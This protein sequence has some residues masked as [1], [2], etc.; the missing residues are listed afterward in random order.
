MYSLTINELTKEQFLQ[1]YWQKKPLL[2][3]AGFTD[4]NDPLSPEELAG[5]AMEEGIE[6][7]IVT[8]D[9]SW[10][11]LNGP[12]EDFSAL[13]ESDSTLL[14]QAVDHWHPEASQLLEPF[15]FIP[16][17]R[18]DDLMVSY[19]T[20]GG[21]VGPHLDQ[22][23]VFIIQGQGQRHW[24]VGEVNKNLRQFS[25][26]KGLLQV[27][28]FEAVIDVQLEPG[29]ILYIPPNAPHEGYAVAPS[30][31]YS[32]GFRAPNQ[33]D[34]MSA[35]A[36]HLIDHDLG[37]HRYGDP[38]LAIRSSQGQLQTH[39]LDTLRA[40]M[41][42]VID[43]DKVFLRFIGETL[44][45]PKHDKD[46]LPVEPAMC[47]DTICDYVSDYP[48][49][50]KA[51]GLRALYITRDNAVILFVEGHSFSLPIEHLGVIRALSDQQSIC[52]SELEPALNCLLFRQ[53]LSTLINEGYWYSE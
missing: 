3:K 33:V 30:L 32:V 47:A 18:I 49:L 17:W 15:R 19:S 45:Q 21:G 1:H 40:L 13:G 26:N 46:L 39:E 14:V 43:D 9:G 11:C 35:F 23:D 36:D 24:R 38:E 16:N 31:N 20:P 22:Y 7:R 4:F 37:Q 53:T 2:I 25:A 8:N 50:Y 27:D 28:P 29:D 10:Q 51:G 5:L 52:T 48:H 6:S 12:F 34:L 41:H 44:S 42:Q